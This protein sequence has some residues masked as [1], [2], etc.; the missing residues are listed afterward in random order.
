MWRG[1]YPEAY[2]GAISP[3]LKKTRNSVSRRSLSFYS[4]MIDYFD[5]HKVTDQEREKV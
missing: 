3:P 4:D 5:N 1:C 2:P